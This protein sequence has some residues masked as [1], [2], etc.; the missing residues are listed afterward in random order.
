[1]FTIQQIIQAQ[2]KVK[3]GAYFPKLIQEMKSFA[4]TQYEN[5]VSNG[6]SQYFGANSN[7]VQGES[8]YTK[9]PVN[10][11]SSAE[12]LKQALSIHQIGKTDYKTFCAHSA[13]T[14]VEK[15]ISNL[16]E[17][18]FSYFDIDGNILVVESIP[19]P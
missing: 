4:I 13:E 9:L 18:T 16:Q 11:N 7:I 14:G 17:M 10:R 19:I 5:Y 15:W 1:M 3:S 6:K 2:S 8:K 12:K